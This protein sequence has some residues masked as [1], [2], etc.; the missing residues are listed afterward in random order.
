M[1]GRIQWTAQTFQIQAT[2]LLL[3]P[4]LGTLK[5]VFLYD[6]GIA[7][8]RSPYQPPYGHTTG[9]RATTALDLLTIAGKRRVLHV[10]NQANQ[11]TTPFLQSQIL[12]PTF[13]EKRSEPLNRD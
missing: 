7:E 3:Q 1:Q 2:F 9:R 10:Q 12:F 11:C 6:L 13:S 4:F 5:E 8:D